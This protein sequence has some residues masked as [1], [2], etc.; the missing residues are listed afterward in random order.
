[1]RGGESAVFNLPQNSAA[2]GVFR[3]CFCFLCQ[4]RVECIDG[5]IKAGTDGGI[6]EAEHPLD[7]TDDASAAD[8]GFDKA[9][10]LSGQACQRR[11]RELST[12]PCTA[13][14]TAQL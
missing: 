4:C 8:K 5:S 3:E 2:T 10:V 1:M 11:R 12:E 14:A 13:G 7:I 9:L 6:G